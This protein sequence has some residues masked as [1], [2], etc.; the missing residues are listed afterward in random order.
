MSFARILFVV[1][2]VFF[3]SP[4]RPA[5]GGAFLQP[6]GMVQVIQETSFSGSAQA[7]DAK[8]R[9]IPVASYRKFDFTTLVEYGALDWLTFTGRLETVNARTEGPP[10]RAY[11]GLGRSEIGARVEL[12]QADIY[13]VSAQVTLAAPGTRHVTNPASYGLAGYEAEARLMGGG[14]FDFNDFPGFWSVEAGYRRRAAGV[15][16][17]T[18]LDLSG[19]VFVVE[20][21]QAIGQVFSTFTAAGHGNPA[22]RA[23]KAQASLVLNPGRSWSLQ[24]GAFFTPVAVASRRE[25]GLLLAFWRRF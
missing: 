2:T 6:E 5:F 1:S 9:L 13:V 25:S 18:H 17:E 3:I 16:D 22:G 23:H 11:R 4:A 24:A 7:F 15:P 19:G 14:S 12:W 8:G 10:A 20:W 21:L